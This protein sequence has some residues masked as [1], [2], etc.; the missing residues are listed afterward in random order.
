MKICPKCKTQYDDCDNFCDRIECAN[1]L[2]EP[3]LENGH[4]AK[5]DIQAQKAPSGA[6]LP[7][8]P[9]SLK[10]SP[11]IDALEKSVNETTKA[12]QVASCGFGRISQEEIEQEAQRRAR[13]ILAKS[14]PLSVP[15][16]SSRQSPQL[17]QSTFEEGNRLGEVIVEYAANR[18]VLAGGQVCLMV[19]IKGNAAPLKEVHLWLETWVAGER[20]ILETE[21]ERSG[22]SLVGRVN[23][24][25]KNDQLT[26]DIVIHYYLLCR[27]K[28]SLGYYAFEVRHPIVSTA[29]VGN[30]NIFANGGSLVKNVSMESLRRFNDEAPR[31]ELIKTW[32]TPWRP[33]MLWTVGDYEQPE[34][35]E[36]LTLLFGDY[37]LYV[38]SRNEVTFGR[39][40]AR[41]CFALMDWKHNAS[42]SEYPTCSVSRE[43][44]SLR[45]C[46]D[47]VS[48]HTNK[49]TTRI[50]GA[51]PDIA[52]RDGVRLK[53][54]C[55]LSIG[56]DISLK[57]DV[58]TCPSRKK[59]PLCRNCLARRCKGVTLAWQDNLPEGFALV[60]ECCD[61]GVLNTSLQGFTLYHRNGG[62]ILQLPDGRLFNLVERMSLMIGDLPVRVMPFMQRIIGR[63]NL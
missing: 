24:Y 32:E 34:Q 5:A 22:N 43:Q 53:K 63:I 56:D 48:L 10:S 37:A 42:P 11:E 23:F 55:V 20:V 49:E 54:N 4:K 30:V 18:V 7:E 9:S 26:G 50:D 13:E 12:G 52:A 35:L 16:N 25:I 47:Y 61:L 59:S 1:C 29:N 46:Q 6:P 58:H 28:D 36:L 17:V 33:E 2:L 39:N 57:V 15:E 8:A 21:C 41:N 62:F 14:E 40:P 60:W 3:L 44:F 27:W 51:V 38:T 31:Y 19:R 45:N